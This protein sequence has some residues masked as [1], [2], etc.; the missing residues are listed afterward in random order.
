MQNAGQ[1]P[2]SE[3]SNLV[4]SSLG[5]SVHKDLSWNGLSQGSLFQ[6]PK[7]HVIVSVDGFG[8]KSLDLDVSNLAKYPTK[9]D[10][11]YVDTEDVANRLQSAT[12]KQKPL[13][14]DFSADNS[15]FDVKSH[16]PHMF[17]GLSSTL[18]KVRDVIGQGKSSLPSLGLGSLNISHEADLMLLGELQ[19]ILEIV[20]A[21][22]DQPSLVEDGTPD[23]YHFQLG[24]FKKLVQTYGVEAAKV[25]DA[26]TLL[27]SFLE[28]VT[29]EFRNLYNSNVVI[30]VITYEGLEGQAKMRKAR[31]LMAE[32]DEEEDPKKKYG[33]AKDW[34][35]DFPPIFNIIL[36]LGLLLVFALIGIAF[37]MWNMDP[38]RDSIIY[39]MTSQRIKKD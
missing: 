4:S 36:W 23:L 2:I 30:E 19:L 17:R 20:Q 33:V 3:V 35:I 11:P 27:S 32:G 5:F 6:R 18:Q 29:K 28:Q 25:H 12:F 16:H 37:G 14:V 1:L 26:L 38:G 7:A 9:M 39:R 21:L 31:S 13:V 15:V 24:G 34:D 10:D 8:H 22:K